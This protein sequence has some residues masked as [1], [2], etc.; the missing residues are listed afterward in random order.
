MGSHSQPLEMVRA[1][2]VLLVLGL[3]VCPPPVFD[4][5]FN[6]DVKIVD[7]SQDSAIKACV[8]PS[9]PLV[10]KISRATRACLGG[11]D[12]FDWEDF[13]KL[14]EGEDT[15]NNGLTV[16]LENAETCFY[17]EMGWLVGGQVKKDVIISD[18]GNLDTKVKGG[19]VADINQCSAWDGKLD[20]RM[21]RSA[22][23]LENDTEE[24]TIE[25]VETGGLL[26]WVKSLIRSK[27]QVPGPKK[28][29]QTQRKVVPKQQPQRPALT[30]RKVPPKIQPLG[31]RGGIAPRKRQ[32]SNKKIKK[33]IKKRKLIKKAPST[34]VK[35]GLRR[36]INV[37]IY[38]KLWCFDLAVGQALKKCVEELIKS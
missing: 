17:G 36:T 32:I 38:N 13:S 12:T 7:V 20:S 29:P 4:D 6:E 35:S 10:T 8:T 22:E 31:S 11:D 9:T 19:F 27:R 14:N 15:D 28:I 37:D 18:F 1:A 23:D 26:G 33:K 5:Y 2:L 3:A 16:K 24:D 21:K 30:Q 34:A 25:K